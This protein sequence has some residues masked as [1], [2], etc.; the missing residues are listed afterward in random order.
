MD[1]LVITITDLKGG[2]GKTTNV[3]VLAVGLALKKK[4][5]LIINAD[6]SFYYSSTLILNDY[7]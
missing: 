1:Q 7:Y 4:K 3:V 6:P 5:S 2:V